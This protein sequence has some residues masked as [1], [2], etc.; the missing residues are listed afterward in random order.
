MAPRDLQRLA[1]TAKQRR[2]ELGLAL[3]DA[4]AKV[5]GMAKHTWRRVELGEPVR[6]LSYA[7]LD[8]LLRWA[9]GSSLAV[10]AGDA[11][12]PVEA[13][14]ADPDVLISR[15]PREAIDEEARDVIQLA[16]IATTRGLTSDEIRALSDRVV[17]DLRE[18]GII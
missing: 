8:K 10:L 15:L 4:N 16:T 5:G 13:S 1:R 14:G 17:H 6:D 12:V 11:A 18:R 3:D 7:K 9:P 2:M